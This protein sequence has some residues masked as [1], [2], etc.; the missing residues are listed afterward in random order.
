[1]LTRTYTSSECPWAM[2]RPAGMAHSKMEP[3]SVSVS[4]GTTP[5]PIP[6]DSQ[7]FPMI[8]ITYI[9]E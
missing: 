4:P 8:Y 3:E 7:F 9:S 2:V 1:M 5:D 6:I